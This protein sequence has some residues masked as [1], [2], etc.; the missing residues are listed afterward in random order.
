MRMR[1]FRP[2]L[3][4]ALLA[5]G[6]VSTTTLQPLASTPTTPAGTPLDQ[7]HGVRL[8]ANGAAWKGYPSHL[9]RIVTPVEVRLENQSGRPLRIAPEDFTLVGTSRFEYAALTLPEL[10][11]ENVSGVGGSGQAG[12]G[13][14]EPIFVGRPPLWPGFGWGL[15]GFDPIYDP[16]YGPYAY[17]YAPEPLPTEDMV[18]A[19][20]PQGTLQ[21][22]GA[23][24]G[25]LYFQNVSEREGQV[26]LRARLV[27][28]RT[29]EQ[30]GT[31]DIPFEVRG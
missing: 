4:T 6:C 25:F 16:F 29:G 26:T 12:E 9:G 30:F 17:G 13:V 3:A 10:S 11:Q 21:P 14:A 24:T 2:V 15:G 7:E 18:K 28:A 19:A 27:D 22:G 5:A 23:V 31:L 8:V 20:L 1:A